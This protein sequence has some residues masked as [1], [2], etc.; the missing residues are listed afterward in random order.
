MTHA[1]YVYAGYIVT[2]GTL[3]AYAAWVIAKTRRARR[4]TT[5]GD[6]SGS[7]PR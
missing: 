4:Y 6:R 2:A 3:G 1:A 5:G 7:P